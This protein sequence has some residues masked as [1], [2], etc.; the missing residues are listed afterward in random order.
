MK[1]FVLN[2]EAIKNSYGFYILTDG[3]GLNRFNQNPVMLSDHKNDNDNVIGKWVNI[4]KQGPVLLAEPEFDQEDDKAKKIS[5]K[6]ERGIIKGASMGILFDPDK[7]QVVASKIIL[8]ECE[9][10]EAS[11]VPVPSNRNAIRLYNIQGELIPEEEV[12]SLCLSI[13]KNSNPKINNHMKKFI[14]SVAA[15]MALGFKEQPEDGIEASEVESKIL[16]LSQKLDSL[17]KEN[18]ALKLSAQ[19]A[20]EAQE[21]EL[22]KKV[23][24]Q[25][26]LAITQGKI[27]ADKE[28]SF[29]DL[30]I[31]NPELLKTTLES[32]PAKQNFSAG[33]H[34]P[35]GTEGIEVKTV[36][37]FQ[38]L[39]VEQQLSFKDSKPE[40]YKKLFSN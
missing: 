5:G 25:V 34:T 11:I 9:L 33:V 17:T 3:V 23:G 15:L 4:T 19:K 36:E 7:L 18:E 2:D 8:T 37:D 28:Q 40:E 20:K 39:T 24:E 35:V 13:T 22:K 21:A 14:L 29:I 30:G 31:S 26:K 32:I 38:K 12:K 1:P 6:V 10:V 16:G 27:P